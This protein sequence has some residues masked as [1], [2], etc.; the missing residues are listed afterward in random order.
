MASRLAR[1]GHSVQEMDAAVVTLKAG[2][3][4]GK[5]EK[6]GAIDRVWKEYFE[7]WDLEAR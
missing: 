1:Q 6:V 3:E 2:L 7:V 5:R 4:Q